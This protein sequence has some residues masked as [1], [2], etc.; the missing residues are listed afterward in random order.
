MT[1]APRP[2]ILLSFL[3]RAPEGRGYQTADYRFADGD[4]RR[5]RFF[6][7]AAVRHLISA[8]R[9]LRRW[10]VLGTAG[11]DWATVSEG[12]E[13]VSD[14]DLMSA[15]E[16][17]EG[18]SGES[19]VTDELLDPL[20][21]LIA[22]ANGLESVALRV[23]PTGQS[24]AEAMTIARIISELAEPH[25]RL[26]LDITHGF[27]HLSA[28]AMVTAFGLKWS[29]DIEI[30]HLMY[31]AYAA[32]RDPDGNTSVVDL[33]AC[34]QLAADTA[35]MATFVTTGRYE[36]L[37]STVPSDTAGLVTNA[38][39]LES[40]NRTGEARGPARQAAGAI[41]DLNDASPIRLAAHE[42]LAEALAWSDGRLH[43]DRVRERATRAIDRGDW[44]VASTLC[45]ECLLLA[46]ARCGGR[47]GVDPLKW[48]EDDRE[49]TWEWI[50]NDLGSADK[51]AFHRIRY[52]RNAIAHGTRPTGRDAGVVDQALRSP[53]LLKTAMREGMR[54]LDD[55][56]ER[57]T[58]PIGDAGS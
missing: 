36:P 9:P 44:I 21:A 49:A 7:C 32:E 28:I 48:S 16:R 10:I 52:L 54:V 3:G 57:S 30:G 24:D 18:P 42:A 40:T 15:L 41:R 55:L 34:E 1:M 39:F 46:A 13:G 47:P 37:A 2:E 26:H 35:A 53:E 8:G 50:K 25:A 23:I 4:V 5:A 31:A 17:L 29:Q 22:Q 58:S 43:L 12:A 11:S 38:A 33:A 51:A 27:R 14:D 20:E 56:I 6:G 45:Y 19:A